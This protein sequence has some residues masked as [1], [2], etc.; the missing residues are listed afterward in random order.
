MRIKHWFYGLILLVVLAACSPV[1]TQGDPSA[2]PVL[3]ETEVVLPSDT[4]EAPIEATKA[5]VDDDTPP[6]QAT[7]LQSECTLVSSLPDPSQENAEVF[8][9]RQDDWVLGSP[10]AAITLLEYGDFQ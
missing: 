4:A 7:G 3:T 2:K 1:V 10:D 8:S 5:P 9:V 6:T